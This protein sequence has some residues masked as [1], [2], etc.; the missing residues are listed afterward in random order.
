MK[1]KV[2]YT[3]EVR[4]FL[5]GLPAKVQDK[6]LN[7]IN[8]VASGEVMDADL[9][10]KLK[11]HEIWEF[12]TKTRGIAYRIFAFWD[13][14]RESLVIATHGFIKKQQKTPAKEIDK[15]EKIMAAYFAN[16]KNK[17]HGESR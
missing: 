11:G 5:K 3:S 9:F 16:R 4:D 10:K 2:I 7:N 8:R 14:E 13:T 17:G 6:I 1:F 12:R 15:A